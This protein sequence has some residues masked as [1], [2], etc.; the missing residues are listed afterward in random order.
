MC[1][2][3]VDYDGGFLVFFFKQKTAYEMRISD[4]S[5]DVCSSDLSRR[6]S[7]AR[8]T[9]SIVEMPAAL[10]SAPLLIR[11]LSGA[12][13]GLGSAIPIWSRCADSTTYWFFR[14]GSLP[15]SIAATLGLMMVSAVLLDRIWAVVLSANPLGR[16]PFLSA[17][18]STASS[19]RLAPAKIACAA[20]MLSVPWPLIF[21]ASTKGVPSGETQV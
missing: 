9:S 18:A 15:G 3:C 6:C 14:L 5:S 17:S 21:G 8:A 2:I 16:A 10:S 20:G 11:S 7:K 19:D 13:P 12:S 4:W 1:L